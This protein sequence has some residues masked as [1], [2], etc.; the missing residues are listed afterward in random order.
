MSEVILL[1][2]NTAY[3]F[4][5]GPFISLADAKTRVTNATVNQADRQLSKAGGAHAQSSQAGALAHEARGFYPCTFS[6]GDVDTLGALTLDIDVANCFAVQHK[7]QVVTQDTYNAL[8]GTGNGL[9]AN[10][11]SINSVTSA[12]IR[13]ALASGQMYPFT[14]DNTAFSPTTTQ[15]E[16]S[17]LA[18]PGD[19]HWNG[20]IVLWTS[21]PL[22]GQ[23]T[24]V[25]GYTVTGGRGHFT[26]IALNGAPANGATGLLV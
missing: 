1:P 5:A 16:S 2:Q 10:M 18:T 17:D 4:R 8:Q 13:L 22:A 26:V 11:V 3:T 21:G 20:A 25:T 19:F 12:A 24:R 7:F 6:A 23:R 9:R 14:V 15:F